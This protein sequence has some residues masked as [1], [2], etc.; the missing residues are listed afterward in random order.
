MEW[1]V[2]ATL[3]PLYPTQRG[4]L[5][6]VQEVGWASGPVW[7]VPEILA[8]NGLRLRAVQLIASRYTN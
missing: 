3:W 7:I 4:S 2:N 6:N 5:P 8:P 1:V